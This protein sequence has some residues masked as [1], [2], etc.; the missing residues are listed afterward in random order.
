MP[1][2]TYILGFGTLAVCFVVVAVLFALLPSATELSITNDSLS[3]GVVTLEF[4]GASSQLPA[5]QSSH[6]FE[7]ASGQSA[8]LRLNKRISHHFV[9]TFHPDSGA[10]I[11]QQVS[12]ASDHNVSVYL[13][14][15]L[16]SPVMFINAE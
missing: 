12:T 13:A 6:R 7:L 4:Y 1:K 9:A 11:E 10:D 15:R 2:R 5:G 16:G 8:S 3:A 14:N